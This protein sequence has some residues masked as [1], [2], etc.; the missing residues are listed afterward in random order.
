MPKAT[1]YAENQYKTCAKCGEWKLH[2]RQTARKNG[3][4]AHCKDCVYE[5]Q[6]IYEATPE[7]RARNRQWRLDRY[8]NLSLEERQALRSP[9]EMRRA[10][11]LRKVFNFSIEEY[12]AHLEQHDGGC[13]I[14]RKPPP[15]GKPYGYAVDHDRSCCS[16]TFSCGL[17]VRGVLCVPC[18]TRLAV[19]EDLDWRER[20]EAY[21]L[22][23][24]ARRI[25]LV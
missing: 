20:A 1:V 21:L 5:Q 25:D 22:S 13:A 3:L 9:S 2:S 11:Q 18:N 19:L 6:K 8:A 12:D 7:V 10:Q 16:G 24:P 14:C 4:R 23:P 15:E 17:F